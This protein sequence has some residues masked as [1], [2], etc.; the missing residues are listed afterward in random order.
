MFLKSDS[1][2]L[3]GT[4]DFVDIIDLEVQFNCLPIDFVSFFKPMESKVGT[5]RVENYEV[6]IPLKN[7]QAKNVSIELLSFFELSR[8]QCN[9]WQSLKS[10]ATAV[11]S[12][13]L[14]LVVA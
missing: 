14:R 10:H 3:K 11:R 2:H 4:V 12:L 7:W 13:D 5:L 6:R 8:P 9:V 1:F